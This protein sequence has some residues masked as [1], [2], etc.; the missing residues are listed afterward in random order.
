ML[1]RMHGDIM[2]NKHDAR[3]M[4]EDGLR[5]IEHLSLILNKAK[6]CCSSELYEQLRKGVG[7]S[8]GRIQTELLDVIYDKYP[9]L[10]HLRQ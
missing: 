10:D 1:S 6:A 8:I 3:E 7:L 2:M 5:A 4:R 9:E